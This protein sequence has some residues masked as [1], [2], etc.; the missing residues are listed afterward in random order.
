MA[1]TEEEVL[2]RDLFGDGSALDPSLS[3]F[4]TSEPD[5]IA[6]ARVSIKFG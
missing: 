1:E 4:S 6:R 5:G 2:C 3:V